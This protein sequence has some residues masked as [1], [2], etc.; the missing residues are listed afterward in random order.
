MSA[1][2]VNYQILFRLQRM[3]R[4]GGRHGGVVTGLT[5][6]PLEAPEW[7]LQL[8]AGAHVLL[9]KRPGLVPTIY[10]TVVPVT[11]R[12]RYAVLL[13]DPFGT[14]YPPVLLPNL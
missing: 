9:P 1:S 5:R 10:G 12:Q 14:E 4:T 13:R 7:T 2:P 3:A 6:I 8:L 11:A